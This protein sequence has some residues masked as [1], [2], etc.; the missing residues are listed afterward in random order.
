MSVEDRVAIVTGA[1]Q[2]STATCT[3][4]GINAA[5]QRQMWRGSSNGLL[6]P[7]SPSLIK[8]FRRF[9]VSMGL[10]WLSSRTGF[11]Q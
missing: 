2:G 11:R 1:G 6:A 7:I 3:G 5:S 9:C 10:Q 4:V 8:N